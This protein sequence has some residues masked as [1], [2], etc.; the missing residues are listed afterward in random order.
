MQADRNRR[1]TRRERGHAESRQYS[2]AWRTVCTMAGKPENEGSRTTPSRAVPEGNPWQCPHDDMAEPTMVW[3]IRE[4]RFYGG[5]NTQRPDLLAGQ[6]RAIQNCALT[7]LPIP[8][9]HRM[10]MF[11]SL[12]FIRTKLASQY[13]K[14]RVK[15]LGFGRLPS[16]RS[17]H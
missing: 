4:G 15:L 10:I 3:G 14:Q 13:P 6:W 11:I 7:S 12:L 8:I 5:L 9:K 17:N 1:R 16:S 2:R